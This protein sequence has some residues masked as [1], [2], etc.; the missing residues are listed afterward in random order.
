MSEQEL[1]QRYV[2][3]VSEWGAQVGQMLPRRGNGTVHRDIAALLSYIDRHD[4]EWTETEIY[5]L[6]RMADAVYEKAAAVSANGTLADESRETSEEEARRQ[7]YITAGRHI[8][9]PL[10]YSYDALEPHISK[11]IMQ[12][13]HTKHHQS[14]VDGLNKAEKMMK[15]ARETNNYELLKHWEREAAFHGSGHYLHTIFWNNM[16]P[17]GGGEPHGELLEQ[18]K[19]DFGSFERFKRHFTEAAKSVEGVGWALLVWSPRS[20]RLEIL[21]TEKHQLMTQWDTIP[22]LVLDVW[23][24]AYYLQYKNDRAAYINSWWNIV[25]WRD[26]EERFAQARKLRWKPF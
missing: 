18:I 5:D 23:E 20:H 24:H 14:Y 12:L 25:H 21:Q 7:T 16:H 26:V 15:K 13:H 8:L 11:E 3:Q 2:K 10:P 6:Q 19:R 4:G 1:F 9:P 22:L 17:K